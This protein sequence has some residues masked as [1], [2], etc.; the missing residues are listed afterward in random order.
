MDLSTA[1]SPLRIGRRN[2]FDWP[3]QVCGARQ[4]SSAIPEFLGDLVNRYI[5][6]GRNFVGRGGLAPVG[7]ECSALRPCKLRTRRPRFSPGGP[8]G[9]PELLVG[10]SR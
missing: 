6:A 5:A 1:V 7:N 3:V 2:R 8:E 10:S 4:P 9:D